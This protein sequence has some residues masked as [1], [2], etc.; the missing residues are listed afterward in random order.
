MS[1]NTKSVYTE[2]AENGAILGPMMAAAVICF[3]ASTYHP[4]WFIPAIICCVAVPTLAYMFMARTYARQPELSTFSALWLQGICMFFF[5]SLIM[6]L[7][8]YVAIRFFCPTFM[9]DQ[10]ANF[11]TLYSTIDDPAA[12]QAVEMMETI[13]K[14]GIMPS[15]I[16]VALELVYGAVFSGSLLSMVFSLVVR[17]RG[18]NRRFPS[19]PP[20]NN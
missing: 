18:R 19:P 8:V 3:G 5:G 14:Q 11:I 7:A 20:F 2:G 6:A 15:P 10:V 1:E 4:W 13:Q 16:E 9:A 12:V 17:S